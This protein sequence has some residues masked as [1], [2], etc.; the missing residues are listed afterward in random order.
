LIRT[1]AYAVVNQEWQ[2]FQKYAQEIRKIYL[3]GTTGKPTPKFK[4]NTVR[5]YVE[6]LE[7]ATN[8][9]DSIVL[10]AGQSLTSEG[11]IQLEQSKMK[12]ILSL[13]A[14][15]VQSETLIDKTQF[16]PSF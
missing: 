11:S 12:E 2:A 10:K 16:E 1:D 15:T 7:E 4:I 6:V 5:S 9:L 13:N 14:F 3:G 8:R